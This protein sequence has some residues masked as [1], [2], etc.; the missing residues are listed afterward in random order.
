MPLTVD[1][2]R[3]LGTGGFTSAGPI[4]IDTRMKDSLHLPDAGALWMAYDPHA[5]WIAVTASAAESIG[6]TTDMVVRNP[7]EVPERLVYWV[8]RF[9]AEAVADAWE[10]DNVHRSALGRAARHPAFRRLRKLG[11]SSIALALRRLTGS[12]RPLWLLF[13]SSTVSDRP[14]AGTE[15]VEDAAQAW[16]RWGRQY[17]YLK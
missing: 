7:A 11:G 13:L 4:S 9:A 17:R 14:A 10:R 8:D 12:H 6:W 3:F 2:E 1:T 15:T 16:R 5:T